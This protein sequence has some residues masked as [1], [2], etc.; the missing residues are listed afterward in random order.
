MASQRCLFEASAKFMIPQE[1]EKSISFKVWR[2]MGGQTEVFYRNVKILLHHWLNSFHDE[3]GRKDDEE[4]SAW[5][6][7]IDR[8]QLFGVHYRKGKITW[9]SNNGYLHRW[10]IPLD[11]LQDG[12][13][14]AGRPVGNS[15]KFMSLDNL[16]NRDILQS[17][18]MHIVLIRYIVDG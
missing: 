2:E 5:G 1:S 11:E 15:P 8:P 10:L 18:R 17:L 14:Y 9:I 13:P 4:V 6:W 12:T 7:C 3:W 16:L